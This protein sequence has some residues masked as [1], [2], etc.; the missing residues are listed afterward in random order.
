MKFSKLMLLCSG[1][2]MSSS[3]MA[4]EKVKDSIHTPYIG[5]EFGSQGV[6]HPSIGY[7]YQHGTYI[8]DVNGGYKYAL[9]TYNPLHVGKVGLN[10]YKS[11][12]QNKKS[13]IYLGIGAD[14]CAL[15]TKTYF[16]SRETD[17]ALH[18]SVSI[19]HDFN[20]DENKKLFFELTYKPRSFG[21]N[22]NVSIHS[23]GYRMGVGF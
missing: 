19:G 10:F 8:F 6:Y 12:H 17:Y 2:L 11:I 18:P 16:E 22:E 14:L 7:R 21:K 4:T 5:Y 9:T 23:L 1:L 15:M 20:I 13:Q 3:L